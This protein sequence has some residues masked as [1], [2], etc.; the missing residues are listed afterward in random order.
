MAVVQNVVLIFPGVIVNNKFRNH[1]NGIFINE[2][3]LLGKRPE[4]L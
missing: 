4:V 1:R 2:G 3:D